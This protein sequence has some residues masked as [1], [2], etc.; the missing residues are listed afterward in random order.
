MHKYLIY[1]NLL[2]MLL[3]QFFQSFLF[4]IIHSVFTVLEFFFYLFIYFLV[5]VLSQCQESE[6]VS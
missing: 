2:E 3:V 6:K 5:L 1:E 4:R